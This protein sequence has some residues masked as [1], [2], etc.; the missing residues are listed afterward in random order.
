MSDSIIQGFSGNRTELIILSAPALGL[1]P[2]VD[3][4][5]PNPLMPAGVS[6]Y[7]FWE[8]SIL[9]GIFG[10]LCAWFIPVKTTFW[11]IP[12]NAL[13]DA[14]ESAVYTT[15]SFSWDH[16]SF[17]PTPRDLTTHPQGTTQIDITV[18][19]RD[20]AHSWACL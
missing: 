16:S 19:N 3:L 14:M 7:H 15:S 20:P 10:A 2:T 13:Q 1:L 12:N 17:T 18:F 5:F 6:Y 9:T 11:Q 8:V 4:A